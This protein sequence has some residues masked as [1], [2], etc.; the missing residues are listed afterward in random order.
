MQ[1]V[2]ARARA[3][4]PDF[5]LTVDNLLPLATLC[6]ARDGLP[7]ALELAAVRLR[8]LS[9]MELV[10]QLLLLRGH[11]Q[12]SSTWLHQT[13]RNIAE[14]HRT[15]QAAIEWSTRLLD[16][17]DRTAFHRLGVFVGGCTEDAAREI[18]GADTPVMARLERDHL[19]QDKQGHGPK[20]ETLS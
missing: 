19:K 13:R 3:V 16:P 18:A 2:A 12:L 10:Q 8:D 1:L 6:V 14:R 15:L 4:D 9:P 17:G 20:K 5:A 7:L 11:T